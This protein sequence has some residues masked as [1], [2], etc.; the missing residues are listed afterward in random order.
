M[1]EMDVLVKY[2][3]LYKSEEINLDEDLTIGCENPKHPGEYFDYQKGVYGFIDFYSDTKNSN[4]KN[5]N[6]KYDKYE[7]RT[8]SCR[9]EYKESLF[10]NILDKLK[11]FQFA[12]DMMPEYDTDI[13]GKIE[14]VKVLDAAENQK[15]TIISFFISEKA[16]LPASD[17]DLSLIHI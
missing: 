9:I 1:K 5:D 12:S 13:I 6:N 15:N 16:K 8:F 4:I 14:T 17:I 7:N 2:K 10:E 3:I 11:V